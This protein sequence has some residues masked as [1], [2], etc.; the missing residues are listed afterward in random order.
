VGKLPSTGGVRKEGPSDWRDVAPSAP[1]AKPL[2]NVKRIVILSAIIIAAIIIAFAIIVNVYG[3]G[4]P[5]TGGERTEGPGFNPELSPLPSPLLSPLPSPELSPL[6]SPLF[7][8]I[9]SPELSPEFTPELSPPPP[10][11]QGL[12]GPTSPGLPST[13]GG[14]LESATN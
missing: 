1:Q 3:Q 4:L 11:P 12:F 14:R 13:G 7:S 2:F 10:T 5:S 6:P 9:L 8:P